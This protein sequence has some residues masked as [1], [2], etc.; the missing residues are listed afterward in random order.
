MNLRQKILRVIDGVICALI[1]VLVLGSTLAFGGAVWWFRPVMVV[2]TFLLVAVKLI[3]QML[4]GEMRMLK[5]PL[6]ALGLLALWLG[7]FQLAPLPAGLASCVSPTAHEAYSRGFFPDLVHADD[8][9]ISLP[10]A[11]QVR[12][13]ASLDRSATLRWLV[14]ASAC[15]GIFWTVSH[16]TDR[17]RR[18]YLIWGLVV[19]G[20]LL[21]SAL[22]I[23]QITNRSD[24]LYGL[25]LPGQ[26]PVWAPTLDDLM[27][28]PTTTTLRTLSDSVMPSASQAAVQS[29]AVLKPTKPFL[30]GTMMGGSG[31]LLALGALAMPLTLAIV[32]HML[33]PRGSRES[34]VSRL[35]HSS[36]GSLVILLVIL[37][38]LGAFLIGL[39][40]GPWSCLPVVLGL[41]IVG[42]P[43]LMQPGLRWSALGLT[44]G[45][46]DQYRPWCGISDLLAGLAGRAS[47]CG[48]LGPGIS[49]GTLVGQHEGDSRISTRWSG[50][51]QLWYDSPVLQEE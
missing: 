24:G 45:P 18:L 4:A 50:S 2:L 1:V 3:Q 29:I 7:V 20:F 41:A 6:M 34:L 11:P 35:G 13:P 22:A 32:L 12:S 14:G 15:L 51:G 49:A 23:V 46:A 38:L 8:P 31:A 33:S 5:S 27:E 43:A 19:A 44:A 10:E 36:Q 16:F 30:F 17:L 48:G 42:F 9:G 39:V 37:A 28:T 21:N 40:A 26:G 47:S 25:Y